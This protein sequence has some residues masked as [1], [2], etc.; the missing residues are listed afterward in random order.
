MT[1]CNVWV[2]SSSRA[3][4]ECLR[5][6]SVCKCGVYFADVVVVCL[7]YGSERSVYENMDDVVKDWPPP[8]ATMRMRMVMVV[9]A[10]AVRDVASVTMITLFILLLTWTVSFHSGTHSVMR[11]FYSLFVEIVVFTSPWMLMVI[12]DCCSCYCCLLRRFVLVCQL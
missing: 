9:W 7:W 12:T 5:D 8:S 3:V 11:S 10:A 6:E 1:H 4:P 2:A